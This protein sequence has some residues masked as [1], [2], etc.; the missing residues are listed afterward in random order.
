VFIDRYGWPLEPGAASRVLREAAGVVGLAAATWIL[1]LAPLS[2][3]VATGLLLFGSWRLVGAVFAARRLLDRCLLTWTVAIAW[4]AVTAELL[5]LLGRMGDPE[6]WLA[7][8]TMLAVLGALVGPG[9][10][11]VPRRHRA[12]LPTVFRGLHWSGQALLVLFGLQLGVAFFLTW[13][14]GISVYD[15]I[16]TYLPQ[17]ARHVQNGSFTIERDSL[18][19]QPQL[20][21]VLLAYQLVFLKA[22]ALVNMVSVM[23][24][25]MTAAGLYALARSFG[26]QG[27][28]PLVAALLPFTMPLFLLHASASRFDI[29]EVQ[30]LLFTLYFLR[31]GYASTS[32]VWLAAAA[33]AFGL[34]FSTKPTFWFAA[35]GLAIVWLA[36]AL[37]AL[38]RRRYQRLGAVILLCAV[39]FVPLGPPYIA[40]NYLTSG[41]LLGPPETMAGLVGDI[42]TPDERA[43]RLGLHLFAYA[44]QLLT[45]PSV[46]PTF[47]SSRVERWFAD[48]AMV[49]GLG[50]RESFPLGQAS[51]NGLI[52]HVSER[53]SDGNAGFGAAFLLVVFPAVVALLAFPRRLGRRAL[54]PLV[55]VLVGLSYFVA[56]GL[57]IPY[58]V[59]NIRYAIEPVILLTVAV[60]VLLA[61]I[62]PRV[63]AT[64]T[65]LLALPLL[66]E[67]NDVIQNNR[68][69]P[70]D[71]VLSVPREEQYHRF[72]GGS[73]A[74]TLQ[75]A[76]AL[77]YKYPPSKYPI[78]YFF[79]RTLPLLPDYTFRGPG[80]ER[81]FEYFVPEPGEQE[82]PGPVLVEDRNVVERLVGEFEPVV[83]RLSPSAYLLLP[84]DRLQVV[85]EVVQPSPLAE[86]LV[87]LTAFPPVDSS[88]GVTFRWVL[89]SP[90][91]ERVLKRFSADPTLEV[92]LQQTTDGGIRVELRAPGRE[93]AQLQ[94]DYRQF[95]YR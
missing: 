15:T 41:Y 14:A 67:M 2:F 91:G 87:H 28:V 66:A 39:L 27:Y 37:R 12:W 60:P 56:I 54:Y 71:E 21:P 70:P 38:R 83:D 52:R 72:F 55:I 45:P 62:R 61:A 29:L 69:V 35:P 94:L 75:A 18:D 30:W 16:S 36:V 19:Y 93:P 6:S 1:A 9:V 13:Y 68:Q 63:A 8:M 89:L 32:V 40:R 90:A 50:I 20:Y 3:F 53:Y 24:A 7:E 5:S 46:M 86:A 48:T 57:S 44:T 23:A 85:F 47:V 81:R 64:A 74:L 79:G 4:L 84:R 25:I 76:R 31:R 11:T 42:E 22:D 73:G 95:L 80:L 51:L 49:L 33:V 26:C 43:R 77:E 65:L 17:A 10:P 92:P 78:V 58:H 82:L 88:A 59:N 34:A